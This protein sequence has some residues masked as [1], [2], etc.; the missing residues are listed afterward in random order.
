M[1]EEQVATSSA[2]AAEVSQESRFRTLPERVEPD[3]M[4]QSQPE[5][6]RPDPAYDENVEAIR[7]YGLPL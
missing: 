2:D 6:P 7:W 3:E 1:A 4:V 5:A